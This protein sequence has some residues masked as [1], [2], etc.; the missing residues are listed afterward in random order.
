MLSIDHIV[1]PARCTKA[2]DLYVAQPITFETMRRAQKAAAET[3]SVRLL[4]T[5][6]RG[7]EDL[8]PE[9]FIAAP[10]LPRSVLDIGRFRV[11]RKLP[12]LKDILDTLYANSTADFLL[13]TNV[14]IALMPD[15][16]TEVHRLIQKGHDA[17]V[18]NRRTIGDRHTSI[19]DLPLLYA[20]EGVPHPGFD[21]FV[22]RRELYSHFLIGDV[23]L[24]SGH[25]DT[26]LMCSMIATAHSF[27]LIHDAHLTFHLGDRRSW[28]NWR[29]RDY[30]RHNDRTA[31]HALLALARREGWIQK[32]SPVIRLFLQ[33]GLLKNS[34][35][36]REWQRLSALSRT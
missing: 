31:S 8:L 14:D 20:D 13:Y 11:Q 18:I 26:P 28:W 12:L 16:Y 23:C 29:Y 30:L 25:V 6:L 5:C 35:L 32:M 10:S 17:I 33:I 19:D 22:F 15:F 24:G 21:C 27:T 34:M 7:E 4:A 1:V 9:G 3:V 36:V 2:S